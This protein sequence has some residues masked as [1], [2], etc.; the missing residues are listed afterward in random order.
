[1]MYS[2]DGAV[3]FFRGDNSAVA[4]GSVEGVLVAEDEGVLVFVIVDDGVGVYV[5]VGRTVLVKVGGMKGVLD[6]VG[7][8]VMVG[9]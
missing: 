4:Y 1:M 5:I 9:V 3:M 7:V 8:T 6:G 2:N